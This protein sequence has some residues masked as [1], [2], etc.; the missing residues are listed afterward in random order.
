MSASCVSI[1]VSVSVTGLESKNWS[2][3]GPPVTV[4]LPLPLSRMSFHGVPMSR[5]LPSPP[6]SCSATR[7][8]KI[9]GAVGSESAMPE[10][11]RLSLPAPEEMI[12]VSPS[13]RTVLEIV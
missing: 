10:A 13:P 3:P 11:S 1:S 4:S 6:I 8:G 5:S 9:G 7:S 2:K 12:S